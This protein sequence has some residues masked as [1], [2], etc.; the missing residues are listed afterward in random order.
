MNQSPAVPFRSFMPKGKMQ[1]A[2]E[3]STVIA[4]VNGGLRFIPNFVGITPSFK[5]PLD[6]MIDRIWKRV[7]GDYYSRSSD[8]RNFKPGTI[9]DS[10]CASDI[11]VVSMVVRDAPV[12]NGYEPLINAKALEEA[13][14]KLSAFAKNDKAS[15]HISHHLL[16]EVPPLPELLQKYCVDEGINC[17]LYKA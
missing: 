17:Y 3:G 2:P 12:S 11:F 8:P 15:L 10:L 1:Q 14:K 7:K 13:L 9:I 6:R 5:A 4:P 16:A